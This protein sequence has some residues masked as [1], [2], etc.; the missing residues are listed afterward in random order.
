M[1]VQNRSAHQARRLAA[2]PESEYACR[3]AQY[4]ATQVQQRRSTS[5]SITQYRHELETEGSRETSIAFN[6]ASVLMTEQPTDPLVW[7]ASAP[8]KVESVSNAATVDM[9]EIANTHVSGSS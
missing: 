7:L 2:L 6:S 4:L 5:S 9:P 8:R 1:S 3:M